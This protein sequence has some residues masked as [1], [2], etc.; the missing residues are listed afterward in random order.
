MQIDPG[1]VQWDEA[2]AAGPKIDPRM[3]NWV[4][5]E[6]QRKGTGSKV[7]DAGNAVGTGYFRGLTTLAGL[8]VDTVANVIDL[9]K[10]AIGAPYTALTGK[11]A[12]DALQPADRRGVVGS[13]AWL[14][15]KARGTKAGQVML[16]AINPE[17]QGGYLQA[18][19]GGLTAITNPNSVPQLVNQAVLGP[20]S[21]AAGK[22]AYD[23]TG[24][25]ALAIT[26]GMTPMGVQ[27]AL[28][29]GVKYAVRGGEKGRKEMEQRIQDL[30]N[31]GVEKP[32]IGLASGNQLIGGV[33]NLLQ[34]TPGAVNVMRRSR[35]AAVSGLQGKTDAAASKAS[36]DRGS[37]EA[38]V[39]VQRGIRDFKEGFKGRQERLYNS[40]DEHIPGS[41]PV[42]VTNTKNRLAELNSDIAGA[43]ELSK[44]FKNSRIQAIEAAIKAD[45]SG[46]PESVMVVR[47]PTRGGGGIMNAPIEQPPLLVKIPQEPA[48]NTLPFEAVKKTRTLVGNEIADNSLVSGVPRSKWNPLYG[49]LSEDMSAAAQASGPQATQAL[50]RANQYSRAGMGRLDRV[51]PFANVEAPERA[52]QMLQ[53][54]LGD[55]LSTLQAVKKTLPEGARGTVA[56]TVIEKLGTA[57]PGK[58][59]ATGTEWSPETFLTNWNRMKPEARNELFSGFSNSAQVKADVDAVA[60][61]TSMMRDNSALWANPSGTA[62]NAAARGIIGTVAGGGAAALAGLLNPVVPIAAAGGL[63]GTN[64]LARSLTNSNNVDRMARRSYIDPALLD[65]QAR[66]LI[67][68]GL[69]E[70]P[71]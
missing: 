38:G 4:D 56:G 8:P 24:N 41:T 55:N 28:N 48:R 3:V 14:T 44:Q 66:A 51:A 71:K 46:A 59:N 37:L 20:L 25:T 17:Y 10:A 27:M 47:Q 69:L 39:A 19:G 30:R 34:S 9:G 33:E 7:V 32:T 63:L 1:K 6:P 57:N 16:D 53:R 58:Q 45:T 61:A 40:L 64:L 18:M 29:N 21:A 49:A 12:P 42:S 36:A 26:A 5:V 15:E 54:T 35:D 31:A 2:P 50:N 43:P 65:A 13:G 70:Q 68:S 11:P 67:G 60:K 22:G 23:A 62:A 52:F